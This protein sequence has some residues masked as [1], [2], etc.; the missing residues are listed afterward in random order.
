MRAQ[1]VQLQVFSLEMNL[2]FQITDILK[3]NVLQPSGQ[4][5]N[6]N[7]CPAGDATALFHILIVCLIALY[8]NSVS[9]FEWI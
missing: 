9:G 3:R 6:Q 8:Y 1:R 4:L 2:Q 5:C 7:T